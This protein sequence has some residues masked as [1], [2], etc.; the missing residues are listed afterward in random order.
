MHP[1]F[2][3]KIMSLWGRMVFV[4]MLLWQIRRIVTGLLGGGNRN[5]TKWYMLLVRCSRILA[6]WAFI[7][8][9]V[10]AYVCI[11]LPIHST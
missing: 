4:V 7:G 9:Q 3:V 1:E 8:V 6:Y 11:E 5:F 10:F 2:K